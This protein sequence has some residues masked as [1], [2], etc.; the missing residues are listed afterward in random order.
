MSVISNKQEM[1]ENRLKIMSVILI[2]MGDGPPADVEYTVFGE[3][4]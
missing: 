4:Q 2:L 1:L 3:Q